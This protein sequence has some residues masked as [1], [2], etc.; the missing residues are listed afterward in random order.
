[1]EKINWSEFVDLSDDDIDKNA[2]RILD[3]LTLKEK[4][5]QMS[6]DGS[7]IRGNLSMLKRYN[8]KPIPAG[9]NDRLGIPAI[10][11]S[12]GP[13]GIVMGNS[14]CFPVSIARG[15]TW[16]VDLEERIG[17]VI[18]I[19][20]RAQG[21]NYFGGVCI[22]LIR[23]PAW[24]RA[25]ETYGEDP[26]LLGEMGAA[27]V[28]GVQKHGV[29]ACA[30]HYA[31]NSIENSRFKVSVQIDE[32]TLREVY[33]PHFKKCVKEGVASIMTAYNKVNG[34]W[35]GHHTH[36]IRD[37]LKN[38]WGFRG[39]VISD[40]GLGIRDGKEAILGG[41]DIEMPFKWKMHPKKIVKLVKRGEIPIELIDEAVLR[42]LRQKIKFSN[43]GNPDFY[44]KEKV[45]CKEHVE[46]AL[47]AALKSIVLLKNEDNILPLNRQNIKK[48]A[49]IGK[50]AKTP[51]IGD[52]GSS[53]VRPPYIVTIHEGINNIAGN[54]IEIIYNEGKNLKKVQEIVKNSDV[55]IVVVGFSHKDEGEYI[56]FT[57]GDRKSL[58]LKPNDEKLISTI[59]AIN[60][61]VIVVLEGGSAII[62]ES[63]RDKVSAILM[64]WYPGME[65]GNAIGK[66]IFGDF[67]PCGKLPISFPKNKSQLPY[68]NN[69]VKSIKYEYY[70]GYRLMDKKGY[71]PAFPFGFGMSYST[72]SYNNLQI[73]KQNIKKD[74][75][76]KI[77]IDITNLSNIN[78]EEIV[79]MYVG[80]KNSSVDRPLKELKGFKKVNLGPK[81][82]KTVTFEL[83]ATDL[84]Y[85][86]I[87]TKEWKIEGLEHIIY[88]GPSSRNEDLTAIEFVISNN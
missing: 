31:T 58:R 36:L 88:V 71:E 69:K 82:T 1:M 60:K 65:G 4:A 7:L 33:L 79:Q 87:T 73:D 37:I 18:G 27:L 52:H 43:I 49:V 55:T 2:E 50:L 23:H 34:I 26:I 20:A 14:T 76:T 85:Y 10:R 70:H 74:E 8:A 83:K 17:S 86:D 28:R 44:K 45:A 54:S 21:A 6:G 42:I 3:L 61:K 47:E 57:A 40:F 25:Q 84:R 77:S 16:D 78:G 13:R 29:M 75:S 63:W 39:F 48:I 41:M 64:A 9:K 46:L 5:K 32:R 11:F 38:D 67:N 59:A 68:F 19:E 72:F 66:I 62:T 51:N 30:K 35:C 81:E 12:D 53:R 15:A 24:G 80:F 22:N 56:L